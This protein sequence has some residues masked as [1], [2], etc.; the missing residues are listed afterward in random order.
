MI[1]GNRRNTVLSYSRRYFGSEI[2]RES[3]RPKNG[4]AN[5]NGG[6]LMFLWLSRDTRSLCTRWIHVKSVIVPRLGMGRTRSYKKDPAFWSRMISTSARV[7]CWF[8]GGN[9]GGG[10]GGMCEE[11]DWH[12]GIFRPNRS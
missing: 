1:D 12:F 7:I 6:A 4:D 5:D 11:N 9:G 2:P 3:Q 8:N 10:G